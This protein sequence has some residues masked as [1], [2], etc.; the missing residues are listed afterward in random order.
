MAMP[1]AQINNTTLHYADQGKG[2]PVVLVHGFPLDSRMWNNQLQPLSERHRVIAPDLRGFGQ[3]APSPN[4]FTLESLADDLHALA[5]HLNLDKFTLAG[6]SMGG[7][8]ALAYVAKYQSTLRSLILVDTKS[9]ADTPEGKQGRDKMIAQARDQGPKPIADAMLPK[10]LS[11][12]TIESGPQLAREVRNIIE[13]QRKETLAHALAAMRDRP[14]RTP[15]LRNV[16]VPTLI[17]VGEMDAITPPDVMKTLK[18]KIKTSQMQTIPA[19]GHLTPM[20]Q[21]AQVN[22]AITRLLSSL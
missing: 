16:T 4:P 21:P 14:D 7:Y 1:S 11:E 13:S 22:Q 19:A 9:Q 2:P 8:I 12:E 6:L 15:E 18:D 5:R 10:L 20:E 3:S 17:I